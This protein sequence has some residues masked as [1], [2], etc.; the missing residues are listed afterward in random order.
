MTISL[1]PAL[2]NSSL[3]TQKH[4][5]HN[6]SYCKLQ[7]RR[8]QLLVKSTGK[9]QP[10]HLPSLHDEQLLVNCLKHSLVNL[11]SIDPNIGEDYLKLWVEAC[12]EAGKPI[13][14]RLP[15]SGKQATQGNS[16]QKLIE[17]IA[18]LFLLLLMSP[19][20]MALFAILQLNSPGSVFTSEW[21]VGERGKLFRA[22]KFCTTTKPNITPLCR[23]MRKYDLDH[24]PQLWNVLRGEMSLMGSR[25]CTLE[26]A[27]RLT[28][29]GQQQMNQLSEMRNSW[30]ESSLLHLDSQTL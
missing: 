16:W 9:N 21:Q 20:M 5:H 15:S 19:V 13:F 26:Q 8:G 17:W 3:E 24:L 14:L 7:W 1:I 22:I 11:V 30:E 18:A 28:L 25:N 4:Q 2:Q 29:A 12:E 6:F 23:W 27:V 10:L